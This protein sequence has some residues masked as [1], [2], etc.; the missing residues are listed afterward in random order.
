[1]DMKKA[2]DMVKHSLLF[3]KLIH[4]NLSPIFVRLLMKMYM[5]QVAS[6]RWEKKLSSIFSV[7]NGVK[8][9]AVLSSIL[10]CI[11]INEL[12]KRLIR[13]KTGCWIW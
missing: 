11:Y 2:F 9:G 3:Q 12:I 5:S 10:F 1:M 4:K 13:N 6:V 8:Q 7:T